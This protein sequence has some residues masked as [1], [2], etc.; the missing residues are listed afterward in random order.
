[1]EKILHKSKIKV[2]NLI[3]HG[4]VLIR[5]VK[6]YTEKGVY[7]QRNLARTIIKMKVN[8]CSIY[9][10]RYNGHGEE[11]ENEVEMKIAE[12]EIS[13][14]EKGNEVKEKCLIWTWI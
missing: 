8:I 14:R 12:V 10:R 11:S 3:P 2:V 6:C 4:S 9:T 1:M 13:N 7:E 5:S